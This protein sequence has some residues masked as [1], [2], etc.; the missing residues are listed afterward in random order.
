MPTQWQS[1]LEF[2]GL[3]P[4]TAYYF[5]VRYAESSNNVASPWSTAS[6]AYKTQ[7]QVKSP[8][9]A[10]VGKNDPGCTVTA[11]KEYV[12]PK[13]DQTVKYTVQASPNYTAKSITVNGETADLTDVQSSASLNAVLLE[14]PSKLTVEKTTEATATAAAV[15]TVTYALEGTEQTINAAVTYD[16]RQIESEKATAEAM[17]L[18]ANDAKNASQQTLEQ[19]LPSSHTVVYDNGV[20]GE[21]PVQ[22][23]FDGESSTAKAWAIKGGTYSYDGKLVRDGNIGVTDLAVTVTPVNATITAIDEK[24]IAIRAN[25]KPYSMAELGLGSTT[26][27]TYAD[28]TGN[29][30]EIEDAALLNRPVVWNPA[31]PGQFGTEGYNAEDKAAKTFTGTVTLPEWAT[32]EDPI[33]ETIVKTAKAVTVSGVTVTSKTYDGTDTAT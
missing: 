18:F 20:E 17:T 9:K 30:P 33:V 32:I 8:T 12:V 3:K 29:L 11:D 26:A 10:G 21:E 7:V 25:D 27:V 16:A 13:A 31:T 5:F 1:N 23:S 4:G 2:T 6:T 14:E 15:Y 19:A 24:T 28:D 22:W